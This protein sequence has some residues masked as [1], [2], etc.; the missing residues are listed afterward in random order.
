M[1]FATPSLK[2][3]ALRLLGQREHSRVGPDVK[4]WDVIPGIYRQTRA[5]VEQQACFTFSN[6]TAADQQAVAIAQLAKDG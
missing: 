5:R 6:I 4:L 1:S 3:R 2:G